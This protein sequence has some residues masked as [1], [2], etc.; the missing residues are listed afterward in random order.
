LKRGT[1]YVT[2][3]RMEDKGFVE[4]RRE[5]VNAAP[6]SIPRRLY[7]PTGRGVQVFR[8]HEQFVQAMNAVPAFA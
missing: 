5:D 1:I 8:A 3:A 4:S 7:K 6:S 2:L